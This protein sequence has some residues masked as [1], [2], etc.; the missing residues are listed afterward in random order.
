MDILLG[1]LN[2]YLNLHVLTWN[3]AGGIPTT[4][5]IEA[6]FLPQPSLPVTNLCNETDI[7][8]VGLQEAYPNVQ[9]AVTALVGRDQLVEAFSEAVS[10]SGFA[11]LCHSRLLG[12]V[13]IVFVKKPLLCY[14]REVE[15][16]T[17]RTGLGGLWGNKGSSSVR[18]FLGDLSIA[19][20]NCH[21]VPHPENNDGRVQDLHD[22]MVTQVFSSNN[23]RDMKLLD[24]DVCI[25]FGDLNFRIEGMTYNEVLSSI[26]D[27][28]WAGLLQKDQLRLEQ[29][30][31]DSSPSFIHYFMEM[32]LDFWP[33]YKYEPAT[34]NYHDGGKGRAPAWCDRVLWA[35]HNRRLPTV[36]DLEPRRIVIP[37]YYGVHVQPRS[38]DH[39]A[40][41]CGLKIFSKL[42]QEPHIM[43][44]LSVWTCSTLGK[45]EFDI[46]PGTV[47]SSWDWIG[48]FP[49]SFVNVD[50]DYVYWCF[51]PALR[52]GASAMTYYGK[53]LSPDQVP[54]ESGQYVLVYKSSHYKCVLGMSP[55]FR[56]SDIPSC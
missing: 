47:I 42:N 56:I 36:R 28:N 23:L 25:L 29:V 44:R 45:I 13:T 7:V 54:S 18:F 4:A 37:D 49:A 48:L 30:K 12:I 52:G 24:H 38:S 8:V 40:V 35:V 1:R 15:T 27:E 53:S 33:S 20:S 26:R 41:S 34:D 5:D 22:V 17:L 6:L 11:R 55:I 3:V 32:Q 9:D 19:L 14:I 31:G 43:F 50:K 10:G 16:C 2:D 39:K 46:T 21:L 51:T